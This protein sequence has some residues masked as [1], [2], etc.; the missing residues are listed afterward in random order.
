MNRAAPNQA[1][2]VIGNPGLELDWLRRAGQS[3]AADDALALARRELVRLR[4]ALQASQ[5]RE[6]RAW[7][8]AR[9]DPLTGLPNR[10]AFE[11][12][13]TRVLS[14]HTD[15]SR[16][17]GLLFIDLDGFKQINDRLG[18]PAGDALLRI[19][20]A[21]LAHAV[22]RGDLVSR[23]GGDEF[24]C[25]LPELSDDERALAIARALVR[26]VE[27]PCRLGSQQV[28]VR[29]SIGIALYPRDGLTIGA[30]VACADRAMYRAKAQQSGVAMA[31]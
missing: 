23:H 15:A 13:S 26:A 3:H 25:L 21:R 4:A 7:E 29:P 12:H 8:L 5:A 1:H 24:L 27:A 20:A 14:T 31:G 16:V 9:R 19:V 10:M 11:T 17:F 28:S 6:A 30:L 22:R 18:H 2:G